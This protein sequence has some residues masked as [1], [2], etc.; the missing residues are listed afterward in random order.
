[1]KLLRRRILSGGIVVAALGLAAG[2][3]WFERRAV[4]A[5]RGPQQ[6]AIPVSSRYVG[7]RE[8]AS[9]HR[10]QAT[11]WSGSQH[12]DSMAEATESNVLGNFDHAAFR[13]AG[14]TSTFFKRGGRLLVRTD[15]LDGKLADFD[16]K[17]T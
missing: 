14:I 11:A 4:S 5:G 7:S 6:G 13:Y 15:G 3:L 10:T 8:C 2:V 16:I 9:C 1:M 17:F 12:H